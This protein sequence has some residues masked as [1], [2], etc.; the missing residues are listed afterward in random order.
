MA[1]ATSPGQPGEVALDSPAL[2][3]EFQEQRRL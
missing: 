3:A 1:I 2:E